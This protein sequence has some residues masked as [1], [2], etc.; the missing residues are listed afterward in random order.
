MTKC[1]VEV[2]SERI[3]DHTYTVEIDEHGHA[4]WCSCPDWLFRRRDGGCKHMVQVQADL[5]FVRR[6]IGSVVG[7][8]DE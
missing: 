7:D 1:S 2:R 5:E 8:D 4:W 6:E 3:L